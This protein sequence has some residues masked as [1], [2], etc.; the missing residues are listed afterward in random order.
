MG[1]KDIVT[2]QLSI[3]D[4]NAVYSILRI[5]DTEEGVT[6]AL[7]ELNYEPLT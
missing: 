1:N 6:T 4:N 5:I 2:E 3:R 7:D